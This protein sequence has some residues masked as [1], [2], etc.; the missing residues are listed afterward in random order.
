M[1]IQTPIAQ[2]GMLLISFVFAALVF[3]TLS[4]DSWQKNPMRCY[5]QRHK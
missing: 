3:L 4:L 2:I 5:R 1:T